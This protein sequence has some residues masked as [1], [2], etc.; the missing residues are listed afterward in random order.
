MYSE[1]NRKSKI[2]PNDFILPVRVCAKSG[3]LPPE[4]VFPCQKPTR[5]GENHGLERDRPRRAAISQGFRM[6]DTARAGVVTGR[7]AGADQSPKRTPSNAA[8]KGES[9]P[10]CSRFPQVRRGFN[11]AQKDPSPSK[12]PAIQHR[13]WSSMALKRLMRRLAVKETPNAPVRSTRRR[14]SPP[15]AGQI[16]AAAAA[17]A[18][19]EGRRP[20]SERLLFSTNCEPLLFSKQGPDDRKSVNPPL[21]LWPRAPAVPVSC[22]HLWNRR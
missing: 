19:W 16:N 6:R 7:Q 13:V 22:L 1:R 14:L 10:E 21:V 5:Q 11:P 15:C 9:A 18:R 4:A 12:Q 8:G 3:W 17:M 2:L 20:A